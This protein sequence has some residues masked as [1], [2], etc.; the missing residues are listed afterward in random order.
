MEILSPSSEKLKV[1]V[2]KGSIENKSSRNPLLDLLVSA[3]YSKI[4]GGLDRTDKIVQGDVEF[5]GLKGANAFSSAI[6]LYAGNT[7][8]FIA[9]T[10]VLAE[11]SLTSMQRGVHVLVEELLSLGIGKCTLEVISPQENPVQNPH[12]LAG[13]TLFSKYPQIFRDLL[14]QWGV[15][16]QVIEMDGADNRLNDYRAA[17]TATA[18]LEIVGSGS[19]TTALRLSR[20]QNMQYPKVGV[21]DLHSVT[22]DLFITNKNSASSWQRAAIRQF[23][24]DVEVARE[25]NQ[26]VQFVFQV[27]L[28][29][30]EKFRALGMKGPSVKEVLSRDGKQ[31]KALEILV[32]LADVGKTRMKL[33]QMGATDIASSESHYHAEP[34]ASSSQVIKMLPFEEDNQ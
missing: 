13:R 3:G 25:K 16:A 15:G 32:P 7:A 24:V 2:P 4:A 10:D 6:D 20:L 11:A 19:T 33:L 8:L 18:A 22:T 14:R 5:M 12:D 29:Q 26:C 21:A 23:G 27:P 9:G 30:V 34:D 1:F 17:T 31:W 28:E